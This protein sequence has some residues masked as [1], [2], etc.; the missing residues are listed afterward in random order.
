MSKS[1]TY[2]VQFTLLWCMICPENNLLINQ[3]EPHKRLEMKLNASPSG[4]QPW[5]GSI[6]GV[7]GR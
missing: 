6:F 1:H 5:L 7:I 2:L 3:T 4:I